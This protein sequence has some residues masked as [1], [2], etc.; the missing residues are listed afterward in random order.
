MFYDHDDVFV[1]YIPDDTWVTQ[2]EP[3]EVYISAEATNVGI[4]TTT[5]EFGI[6]KC[7]IVT[8]IAVTWGGG[9]YLAPP[10]VSIS[11][12]E[13]D[14][15]YIEQVAGIHT[16]TGIST[17]TAAGNVADV[18]ITDAGHG[19]VLTPTVTLSEPSMDSTGDFI[20]NEIVKGSVSNTTGRVRLWNSVTNVLEVA[21]ITGS[22]KLGEM[23]VGQTSGASHK[24][25]IID[26]EPTDDGFADNFNIETEADKIIDFTEQNPFGIP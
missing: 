25:R 8:G 21:S 11:N 19:Y 13:G 22:F 18:Y 26:V 6:D 3:N 15:N 1:N 17:L 23:I 9:G 2:I 4:G 7:G 14:K 16:A 5:F 20:F 12:T 10:L 24:L